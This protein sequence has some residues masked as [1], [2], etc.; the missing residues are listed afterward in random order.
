MQVWRLSRPEFARRLD[1]GGN[2]E[3]GARWNSPGAGVVYTS[4]SLALCVLETL[5]HLPSIRF[6]QGLVA[7]HIDVPEDARIEVVTA[8]DLP[9]DRFS[10]GAALWFRRRGDAWLEAGMALVL[11]APSVIVPPEQNVMVNPRHPQAG[12][13]RVEEEVPFDLDVRLFGGSPMT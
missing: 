13:L 9:R 2:R 7:A 10:R 1:G 12:R 6:V 11:I 5:I 3:T 8:A 4:H